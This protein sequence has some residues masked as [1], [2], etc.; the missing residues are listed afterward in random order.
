MLFHVI[1]SAWIHDYRWKAALA[2]RDWPADNHFEITTIG[3]NIKYV[4]KKKVCIGSATHHPRYFYKPCMNKIPDVVQCDACKKVNLSHVCEICDGNNCRIP[5]LDYFC[6][7]PH[8]MYLAAFSKDN[9][10]IGTSYYKTFINRIVEQGPIM[11]CKIGTVPNKQIAGNLEKAISNEYKI[12]ER[13][14]SSLKERLLNNQ[15]Q[16]EEILCK[17]KEIITNLKQS[18]QELITQNLDD[19]PEY[20][21]MSNYYNIDYLCNHK[22]KFCHYSYKEGDMIKGEVKASI[23][24]FSIL[25]FKGLSYILNMKKLS[26]WIIDTESKG[27]IQSNLNYNDF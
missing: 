8:V 13:I 1:S 25:E 10:K 24:S 12:P 11:V 2:V 15:I 9:I 26:G 19:Q 23:G 27:S 18:R 16:E 22:N 3:E 20:I 4:L 6:K 14:T 17:L 7:K 5:E 21:S